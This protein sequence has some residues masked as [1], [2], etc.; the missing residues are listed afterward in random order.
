MISLG[1]NKRSAG[2]GVIALTLH[3]ARSCRAAPSHGR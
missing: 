2:N 1:L 3:V